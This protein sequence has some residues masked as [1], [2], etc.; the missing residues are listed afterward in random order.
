MIQCLSVPTIELYLRQEMIGGTLAFT[1]AYIKPS[2]VGLM[3]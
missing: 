1:F 3:P 2:G